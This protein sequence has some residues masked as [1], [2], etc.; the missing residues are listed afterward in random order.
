MED[1]IKARPTWPKILSSARTV[2]Y[3]SQRLVSVVFD[4]PTN[5]C[6][7]QCCDLTY[8]SIPAK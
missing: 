5:G 8:N 4:F 6:L 2:H 7:T 3:S 1:N